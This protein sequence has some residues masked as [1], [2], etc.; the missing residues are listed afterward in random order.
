M[1]TIGVRVGVKPE[2]LQAR[3]DR[4][5]AL[6]A[7]I[8]ESCYD[9]VMTMIQQSK[10]LSAETLKTM[11]RRVHERYRSLYTMV[12]ATKTYL[13]KVM[14]TMITQDQKGGKP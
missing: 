1:E 11:L 12:S 2:D 3:I 10:G 8:N 13:T 14:N 9:E 7:R 4:L 5:A 6:E